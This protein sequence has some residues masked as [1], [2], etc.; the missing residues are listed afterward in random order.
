M[1]ARDTLKLGI[2]RDNKNPGGSGTFEI[3]SVLG[4]GMIGVACLCREEE[5]V[6]IKCLKHM[7]IDKIREKN[8]FRNIMDEVTIMYELVG[9]PGVC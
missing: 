1:G 8:L 9:V 6:N 4:S 2:I 7:S 3:A 5:T